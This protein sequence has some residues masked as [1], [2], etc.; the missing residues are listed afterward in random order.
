MELSHD[1]AMKQLGVLFQTKREEKKYSLKE[2][3]AATSIRMLFLQ[4]IE[5]GRGDQFLSPIYAKGFVYQ[6]AA[7]LGFDSEKIIQ[8]YSVA[9]Q[10]E[11][12]NEGLDVK[13][14]ILN[15]RK[16]D[17][18]SLNFWMNLFWISLSGVILF[19]AYFLAKYLKIF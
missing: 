12:P 14:N 13:G 15:A 8:E 17:D 16:Q 11:K 5:E 1:E 10:E 2:V 9:F 18:P 4:A 6:Y 19:L 3:E 7:F